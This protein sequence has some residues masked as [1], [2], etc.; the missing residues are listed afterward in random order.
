LFTSAVQCI[1]EGDRITDFSLSNIFTNDEGNLQILTP[2]S[3]PETFDPYSDPG[4]EDIY[5]SP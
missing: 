1:E 4:I 5:F 2:Y 3:L